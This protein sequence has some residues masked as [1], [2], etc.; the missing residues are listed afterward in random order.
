MQ[1]PAEQRD[2]PSKEAAE[3]LG[4]DVRQLEHGQRLT[5]VSVMIFFNM[6]SPSACPRGPC[7]AVACGE[8]SR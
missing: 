6:E 7:H 8:Y 3:A 2:A 4:E 1:P 5:H